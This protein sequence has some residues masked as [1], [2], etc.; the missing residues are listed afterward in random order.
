M[1]WSLGGVL[2]NSIR[3]LRVYTTVVDTS[4]MLLD[5]GIR[6]YLLIS[7]IVAGIWWGESGMRQSLGRPSS[8]VA[9]FHSQARDE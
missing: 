3:V 6:V 4:T 2:L 8:F 7:F 1:P 5:I 9:V